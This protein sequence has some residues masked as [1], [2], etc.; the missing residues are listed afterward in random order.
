MSKNI[1]HKQ[2]LLNAV[3]RGDLKTT[4]ILC[5]ANFL[6]DSTDSLIIETAVKAGHTEIVKLLIAKGFDY[7]SKILDLISI[8]VTYNHYQILESILEDLDVNT[9]EIVNIFRESFISEN[10]VL[11]SIFKKMGGDMSLLGVASEDAQY[12]ISRYA[13][14]EA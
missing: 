1:I 6:I 2:S 7:K 10:I 11:I 5:K 13:E 3:N 4:A 12:S 9:I 14:I 8:C